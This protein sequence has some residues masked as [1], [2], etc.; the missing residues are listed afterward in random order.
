MS[1]Q[2]EKPDPAHRVAFPDH[3]F[4]QSLLNAIIDASPDGILVVDGK[5]IVVSHNRRFVELWRI[6]ADRLTGTSP[7]SAVGGI[8]DPILATVLERVKDPDGFL[9]RVRELYASPSLDDDSEI[10]LK[11]GRTVERHSTMLRGEGDVYLG[12]VWFFRDVT[13]RKETEATLLALARHDP[14]TGILN[15]R[16][17]AERAEQE[18]VRARRHRTPLAIAEFDIDH[19]KR[20]NDRFGH[21]TGDEVLKAVCATGR[22]MI[23]ETSLFGRIGGE[24]F[25]VLLID[26]DPAGA[27]VFAE[28][29]CAAV[30]GTRV[31]AHG[32]EISCT[33]S[34]GVALRRTDDATAEDCLQRAD[35]AMYLAKKGG[36]NRVEVAS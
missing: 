9:A 18:F 1:D 32:S 12:R 26:A 30:A 6:P 16:Y 15:R 3:D 8:D 19:F 24:E 29:L 22:A 7:G 31:L 36:R 34:V 20:V 25:A 14:L 17:F 10:E 11:D 4:Q 5:G 13:A 35:A 33:I 21:A 23:R 2:A 27:R 28:R